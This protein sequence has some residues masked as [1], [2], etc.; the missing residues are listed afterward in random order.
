VLKNKKSQLKKKKLFKLNNHKHRVIPSNKRKSNQ[1]AMLKM[2]NRR[3]L[4]L[5]KNT[6]G[7]F[8]K[9]LPKIALFQ[10][11]SHIKKQII[12]LTTRMRKTTEIRIKAIL[13]TGGITEIQ[14]HSQKIMASL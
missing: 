2:L 1:S 6:N 14:F 3:N 8:Y 9:L 4:T 11:N 10:H 5:K 12:D 7:I 13:T